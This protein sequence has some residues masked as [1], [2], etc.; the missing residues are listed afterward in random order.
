MGKTGAYLSHFALSEILAGAIIFLS[1]TQLGLHLWPSSA[2]VYGVRVDYLS[3]TLYFS[4]LFILLYFVVNLKSSIL[5]LKSLSPAFLVL[6]TNLLFSLN[7]LATLTWSLRL[8]CYV[9][10]VFSLTPQILYTSYFILPLTVIFQV[11]L[12]ILQTWLGQS[13]QGPFYFLG[14]R[15]LNIS[16]PNVAK[17][18]IFGR[19][20]LRSYGTFSHPNVL[21][22][23]LVVCSLIVIMLYRKYKTGNTSYP[24]LFTLILSPLGL[25]L[26]GSRAALLAFFGIV[27]PFYIFRLP[28][29]RTLYFFVLISLLACVV[30]YTS[31][32][33]HSDISIKERVVLQK[34]STRIIENYPFFGTGANASIAAYPQIN[35]TIRLLQ[36]DHD[37]FTLF[38]SWFGTIGVLSLLYLLKSKIYI[39]ESIFPLLPL[40]LFDHYLLTSPQGLFILLLYI[41][42]SG[43]LTHRLTD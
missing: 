30:L 43:L 38:L 29:F 16:S 11:I 24:I 2:F 25:L 19:T 3:P 21:A 13:L 7:P 36:P 4:D 31:Y 22:G 34:L 12:G 27:V 18:Q 5:H 35:H 26:T 15:A 42:V 9:L 37:S 33:N 23:W 1:A 39:L 10:F 14:E 28:R 41:R 20:I 32:L 17:A 8:M 40:L 6:F